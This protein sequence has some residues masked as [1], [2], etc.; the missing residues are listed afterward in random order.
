MVFLLIFYHFNKTRQRNVSWSDMTMNRC[1]YAYVPLD[2]STIVSW[3][4]NAGTVLEK[5]HYRFFVPCS[6][7]IS[8]EVAY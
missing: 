8:T 1:L 5:C 7:I 2:E 3:P 6:N 4:Y